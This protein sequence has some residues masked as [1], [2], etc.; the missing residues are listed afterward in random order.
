MAESVITI[1]NDLSAK[2][3]SEPLS[4][5]LP[6]TL[7]LALA[8]GNKDLEKWARLEINGYSNINP[9][10]TNDVV[11]P[12]YRTV[13]GQHL[14][15]FGRSL[16]IE[17]PKLQFINEDRLRFGVAE[18]EKMESRG[19]A[20]SI[21]VPHTSKLIRDHLKIEVSRYSFSPIAV[22]GVLSGIRSKLLDW[23]HEIRS[24]VEELQVSKGHSSTELVQLAKW[25]KRVESWKEIATLPPKELFT[26]CQVFLCESADAILG[27][28]RHQH[29][30]SMKVPPAKESQ[31]FPLVWAAE[32]RGISTEASRIEK[33]IMPMM[34]LVGKPD[35][36]S[37]LY[38]II[39]E[40]EEA[41]K[42]L[43]RKLQLE[44]CG[45]KKMQKEE[46]SAKRHSIGRWLTGVV[47][48]GYRITVKSLFEAIL[49]KSQPK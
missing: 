25:T 13:C 19:E 43:R 20:L 8:V 22:S 47:K 42:S 32:I 7:R 16:L 30:P 29:P 3:T 23:L 48:E 38:M 15:K 21:R 14:D 36:G 1:Y 12:E 46:V 49:D 44:I 40:G 31:F 10:L 45:L 33:A 35:Q 2:A 11:V 41:V 37:H 28:Q 17:D 18:L 5:I 9:A 4:Q 24:Y 39:T 34:T 27:R 26:L 6:L